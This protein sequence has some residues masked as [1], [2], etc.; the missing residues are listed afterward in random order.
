MDL[1]LRDRFTALWDKYFD[2]AELPIGLF[3]S[4]DEDCARL[5]LRP[6]KEHVCVIGQL[7][8]ARRGE[9]IAFTGETLGC[10]GGKRYLGFSA[11]LRPGFE[12]F[13]SCGIPGKMEGERYKKTPELVREFIQDA[14]GMK[15]PAKYAVF[16][17]W[18]RL[19]AQDQP[20]V[21][22]FFSPPDVL[23]GLFT[24][25]GFAEKRRQS[26][27]APFGAGCATIAQYPWLEAREPEPRA[28]LGMFDVS[29]RPFVP[30][31]TLSFAVPMAKF[32]QMVADMEESF[33]GTGSW[34]KVRGRIARP[35]P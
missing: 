34:A 15:A 22:I 30:E 32:A 6:A 25:A 10:E 19:A 3:Y 8:A 1:T 7:A 26:V 18:D 9:D 33:L 17:R 31:R 13:L 16:K 5:L 35:A 23:A 29:A 14:P 21:V 20:E 4:D 24:L 12:Y 27:I 2:G 28:V 11:Q